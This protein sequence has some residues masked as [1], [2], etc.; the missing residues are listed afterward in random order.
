[1]KKLLLFTGPSKKTPPERTGDPMTGGPPFYGVPD[2]PGGLTGNGR[3]MDDVL[4]DRAKAKA[5]WEAEYA[6]MPPQPFFWSESVEAEIWNGPY[7]TEVDAIEAAKAEE[8][9]VGGEI[10]MIYVAKGVELD[11]ADLIDSERIFGDLD[12]SEEN[13]PLM[14]GWAEY[15]G[16]LVPW[17]FEDLD[18]YLAEAFRTFAK[19]HRLKRYYTL[20]P[21]EPKKV[22]LI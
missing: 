3:V 13:C 15:W 17:S 18:R 9:E 2:P 22:K 16:K 12:N 14:C 19:D 21:E 8:S 6:G 5:K 11:P 7:A 20:L 10:D 4:H 1:M